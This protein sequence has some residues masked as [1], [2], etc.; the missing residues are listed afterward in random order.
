MQV[1]EQ[2]A[3]MPIS[4]WTMK[5][6]L[7]GTP[8]LGPTAQDFYDAFGLGDGNT[9]INSAD[10]QGV[11]LAAIQGLY[12]LVQ[13]QERRIAELEARSAASTSRGD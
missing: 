7:S 12:Q 5:G 9:T 3:A 1:L 13:E 4:T 2:L 6:D 11:A 10:A 8:H